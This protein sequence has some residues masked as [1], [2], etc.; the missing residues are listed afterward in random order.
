MELG[1]QSLE[2]KMQ[3]IPP[4]TIFQLPITAS[5]VFQE[6][7]HYL[8]IF[9]SYPTL[10]LS[11]ASFQ[12]FYSPQATQLLFQFVHLEILIVLLLWLKISNF[13]PTTL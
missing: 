6:M 8:F 4:Q 5:F 12:Y 2:K 10:K 1:W 11:L 7:F 3:G 13:N 9:K